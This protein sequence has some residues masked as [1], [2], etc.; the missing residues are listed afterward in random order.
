MT[1]TKDSGKGVGDPLFD[2]LGRVGNELR[3]VALLI[4]RLEPMLSNERSTEYLRTPEHMR[5]VQGI[6]LAVQKARGLAAFI[7]CIGSDIAVEEIVDITTALNLVTLADMKRRL[8]APRIEHAE[9]AVSA[10]PC[11]VAAGDLDFF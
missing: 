5:L 1:T 3:D 10:E 7:D 11:K 4:E 6:D 2:V 9:P 8:Q